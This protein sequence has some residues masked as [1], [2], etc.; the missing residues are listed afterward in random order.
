MSIYIS[1]YIPEDSNINNNL[2]NLKKSLGEAFSS[3]SLSNDSRNGTF[4]EVTYKIEVPEDNKSFFENIKKV[5]EVNDN[6]L[7]HF[8]QSE[9]E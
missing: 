5:F 2:L 8:T 3:Y 7:P 1:F 9:I 6:L 4:R